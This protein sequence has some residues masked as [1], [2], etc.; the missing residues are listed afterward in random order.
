MCLLKQTL[1]VS[2]MSMPDVEAG[3]AGVQGQSGL[4]ETLSQLAP[5]QTDKNKTLQQEKCRRSTTLLS[6]S[7]GGPFFTVNFPLFIYLYYSI[8]YKSKVIV[9]KMDKPDHSGEREL[10]VMTANPFSQRG[11]LWPRA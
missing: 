4:R 6:V 10:G 2:S 1:T 8:K 9:F 11:V 7:I 5:C 3:G